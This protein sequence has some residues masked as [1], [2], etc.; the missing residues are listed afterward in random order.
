APGR[1]IVCGTSVVNVA[2]IGAG[3]VLCECIVDN[4]IRS[5]SNI[6][7]THMS[8]VRGEHGGKVATSGSARTW[9]G[10]AKRSRRIGQTAIRRAINNVGAISE[11][12]ATFI[13]ARDENNTRRAGRHL[14]I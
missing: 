12:A 13:H 3:P 10:S 4:P 2:W 5:H 1:A 9:E 6:A 11:S 8:P 14:H 7:P